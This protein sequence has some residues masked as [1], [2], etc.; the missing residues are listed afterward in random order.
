MFLSWYRSLAQVA[1][2]KSE[3]KT[4]G[5]RPQRGRRKFNP[6]MTVEL[7]EYRLAPATAAQLSLPT[8]GFTGTPGT[9]VANYPISMA[10]LS[11]GTTGTGHPIVGLAA[12]TIAVTYDPNAFALPLGNQLA[13]GYVSLGTI[14]LSDSSA[15]GGQADWTLSANAT[16]TAGVGTLAISLSAKTGDNIKTNT[17]GGTLLVLNFPVS[18]TFNPAS[19]TVE[20]IAVVGT[21]GSVHTS[22]NG[23]NGTYATASLGLGAASVGHITINPVSQGN[24][25]PVTPQNFSTGANTM[26]NVGNPA[27]ASPL[28]QPAAPVGGG[29]TLTVGAT[30]YYEVTAVTGTGAA[31]V[32]SSPSNQESFSPTAS[33]G[34][35]QPANRTVTL[36]WA[37]VAGASSYKIYRSNTPYVYGPS[38]LVGTSAGLQF[39]DSGV[40]AL[41][42]GMP[43]SGLLTGATDPQGQ[44]M[45]V[46]SVDGS[47]YTP[48]SAFTLPSGGQVIINSN[49]SFVYTPAADYVGTDNFTYTLA[50]QG[51]NVSNP[52]TASILVTPTL[53]I[54]PNTANPTNTGKQGD[55][56][57]EDVY[58]D[59]PN[60][61]GGFGPLTGFNLSIQYLNHDVLAANG[62]GDIALIDG[63]IGYTT[64]PIVQITGGLGTGATAHVDLV[65][66]GADAGGDPIQDVVIDSPGTGYVQPPAMSPIP[67]VQVKFVGGG[68]TGATAA[69]D[70]FTPQIVAGPD[71]PSDWTAAFNAA[72]TSS[73]ANAADG[74]I[75][76]GVFGNGTAA[77]TVAAPA[78]LLLATF[79]VTIVGTT[80]VPGSGSGSPI[81]LVSTAQTAGGPASTAINGSGGTFPLNPNIGPQDSA[82]VPGVDTGIIILGTTGGTLTLTPATGATFSG[83]ENVPFSQLFTAS[84]G[85][86]SYTFSTT[87]GGL[88]VGVTLSPSGVLSGAP[89]QEGSY[90][91]T[92]NASDTAAATGS[93]TYT[94]V[95]ADLPPTVSAA[96]TSVTVP[97]NTVATNTG[98]YSDY[99]DPVSVSGPGVHDNG[100]GT[101]S[102]S[103]TGDE[104]TPQTITVTAT[105]GDGSSSETTFTV[106]FTDVKPVVSAAS[107]LITVPEN[108]M[109]TNSGTYSDFD[110]A[111]SVSGPGVTDNHNGTWSWSGTGDELTPQTI[112]VTATNVDGSS[113][114]TAFTVKFT[115][116]KPV[117][118][119]ASTSITVPENTTATNSGTYSDFDDAVSVSGPGV[120]DNHNGTW[121][122]SGTGDEL[123]P[124]TITV[125]A[126]NID[127]SSSTTTFT[128][129]FTDVKPVVTAAST[130]VSAPEN[131]AATNSGTYSDFDDAVSVSGPGVTDNHNGTWSWSGT[132]DE[133]TPQT[134][135]V[136]A[137]NADG[138]SSTTTFTVHFTDVKPVV[139]AASTS[140]TVPENTTATNSGTYSD[141]DDA[142][143][144]SGPGVTDNHNGTWSWS[145]TGDELT[146]QT[147]TVTA[148]NVDGSSS[149]TTFTVKFTDVAPVVSAA[150]TA[151]SAPEN[152]AATNTGTYSDFDDTVSVSGPGVTD[153]HNG[154]WSWSGT[155]D[156]LTPYDVTVTATNVDGSSS[157][158]TFHVSFTDVKPT[159]SAASPAVTAP[160]GGTA[161]NTGT[162]SDFDDAVSVSGPGVTDNH[163]GTWSW[164][165]TTT[166]TP[167]D[168]TVTATNAD[169]STN[170]TT[171]LV[172]STAATP[173]VTAAST[174]VSAAENVAATNNGFYS[175]ATG[176][177]GPGVVDHHDGTWS[178]SGTGDELTPYDVTVT[179]TNGSA[180]ATTTFH[181]SFTDVKPAVSAASTSVTVPEN[182]TATN[183]GT[184]SDFDD[185]VSVSGPGVT[186]NHNGTWSWSGTGDE[187]TPQTVTVTATNA[188]GATSTTTFTVQFTD[189]KPV[190]SAASTS[191]TVP[192]NTTATNSGT[193]S[194]FDDAVSVSGPGVTDNHNGTWS[195]SGTGDELAPQTITVTATN[196]D[197]SSSTTT[198]TVHFTDVKPV[199]SAASTSVTAPE[200]SAATNSG[201]YSDFDDAVSVSGPGVTDNHNGTWSW[202]GTGDE[203]TPQ[204]ITV[205]ATNADGSSS[206]TTFSVHFT[207]V[208][209]SVSAASAAVSAPENAAATNTGTYS[210][211]DDAVSVSGP[212]VTDN[213]NGTWSWSGTGDE[214][215]PYNVTVTATNADGST[216]TTTFHVSF[217]D[218]KPVVTAD[219]TSVTVPENTTATVSGTYS[220]FDDAVSVSGPGVVD[221]HDGTW[222]WSGTGDELTPLT[223]TV[224]ATNAD[225]S[226]ATTALSVHFTEV[227]PTFVSMAKTAL[228]TDTGFT[229]TNSG[230][231]SE[232]D[233]PPLHISASQGTLTDH[234]DGTW[235]WSQTGTTADSG[236]VT[237]TATN[238]DGTSTS[239]M[240]TVLF[241]ALPTISTA[242]LQNGRTGTAYSQTVHTSGGTAPFT[243]T[244]TGTLPAGL[245]L[246]PS[247]GVVSGTPTTVGSSTFTVSATDS[248][249]NSTSRPYTVSVVQGTFLG[250][251][252][253]GFMGSEGTTVAAFPVSIN[254]LQDNGSFNG[255]TN[256]VG[257]A[258]ANF[259]ITFPTG[260][261]AFPVGSNAATAFVHLGSVP[262][263]FFT[264]TANSPGDGSLNITLQAQTGHNITT[265]TPPGGGTLVTIDFPVSNTF[266]PAVDTPETITLV[267]AN[268]SAHTQVQGNNGLY[269]LSPGPNYTGSITVKN[270]PQFP[271]TIT[272]PQS[273]VL[274]AN[275][276]L[277]T[278]APG[279]LVGAMDP[280]HQTISVNRINGAVITPG[281]PITLPSGGILQV[282]ANGAFSYTPASNFVGFDVFTFTA[283]DQGGNESSTG[284]VNIM[285]TATLSLHPESVS[286]GPS[287]T[288]VV[289]DVVLDNPA[290][291]GGFGPLQGFNVALTYDSTAVATAPDGSQITVG[292]N[293]PG[294]WTFDANAGTPGVIAIG[295]FN[296]KGDTVS[297]PSPLVLASIKFT[298]IA[299]ANQQT[300]VKIVPSAKAGTSIATTQLTGVGGSYPLNPALDGPFFVNGV[301]TY[302]GVTGEPAPVTLHPDSPLPGDD[303]GLPYLEF[304]NAIGGDGGPFS[305]SITGGSL[306]PGIT[307]ATVSDPQLL[308]S[309]TPTTPG[310]FTFTVTA[311]DPSSDSGSKLYSITI[312]PAVSITTTT[313]PDWTVNQPGYNST[314]NATGGTGSY[315]FG[316]AS[317]V[318]PNG[319]NLSASGV[320]SGTPTLAGSYSFSVS[321]S[322]TLGST[323]TKSYTVNINTPVVITTTTLP[324]WTV[325]NPGYNKTIAAT[326]GTGSKTFSLTSGTLP[327]GLGLSS[328]GVVSGTPTVTGTYTFAVTATDT[329]GASGSQSYT[330][331]INPAVV[332]TT[333]TLPD[334]TAGFAGYNQTIAATG[335]TGTLTFSKSAGTVPTGLI[336]SSSG[337]LSGTPTVAGTYNFTITA[338]DTVGATGSQAYTVVINPAVVITTTTLPN[339]T[340]NQPNYG[341]AGG[342][343]ISATGGT[344]SK[345]FAT[346]GGTLPTGLALS[347]SGVLS[348][349]PTATGSFTFQVTAT[350]SIG[351]TSSP[352]SYTVVI[353]SAVV[354]TTTTLPNWTVNRP[355]Y[356]QNITATG[357]TGAKTFSAPAASLPTGMTLSS[358]G[359]LSGTP[360]VTGSYTFTVTATDTVGATGTQT[361][362]VVINSTPVITTTSLPN[363]TVNAPGY[364]QTIMESGGTAPFTYAKTGGTL[365]TGLTLSAA[366]V[367]SGTPTATGTFLFTITLT[368]AAS[369]TASQNYSVTISS[370]VVITTTTLANSTEGVAG[371]NQ[372]ITATGGTGAKTFSA[373]AAS[374]PT[375]LTLSSSGVLSGTPTVEGSY[376]FTVTATD[377]VGATGSKAFTVVIADQPPVVKADN[378]LVTAAENTM[379]TNTGTYSDFDDA[380]SVSGP[381][382]T[383]NHDGTW[384]WSGSGDELTPQT[385]TVTATNVD[386]TK[387]TTTFTAKFTD[388][389]PKVS[390]ASTSIT[391]PENT[392]ATNTGT[393]SDFDDAVSVS[394]P[395]VTDN[396]NGTWS[397]SGTGDELT[398]QTVTVTATNADGSSSSTTFTVHFTDVPPVVTEASSAITATVGSTATNSGTYSDFDDAVS[399]SGPGVTDNHNGTWSWS[400][401]SASPTTETI[402]VTATNADGS[403][404]ST[405]FTVTFTLANLDV[406]AATTLV[407]TGS[408]TY[409]LVTIEGTLIDNGTLT[410]ASVSL[411]GPGAVLKGT[412]SVTGPVIVTSMGSGSTIGGS[413]TIT[414]PGGT[415]ID[416]QAGAN[417]VSISGV[418]VTGSIIA[419]LD[420]PGSGNMT[421]ITGNTITGNATGLEFLNGCDTATGNLIN[422]N[423]VGVLIPAT[424]P[425]NPS[426]PVNPLL[427]LEGNDLSG[428]SSKGMTNASTMGVTAILNWWG[429]ASGT[430]VAAQVSGV[431]VDNY[432][433]YA[434]DATSVGPTP[435]TFDFFNGTGTDGNVY[436]TGT[437][438]TDNIV[439]TVDSVNTN[440]VHVTG[441]AAPG[442][443]LRGGASN[444]II[445]YG[446][447]DNVTGA[448]DS[449]TFGGDTATAPWGAQINTEALKYREPIG[450]GGTSSSKVT[451]TGFGNDVIFGGG[452]DNISDKTSGN[453]VVVVGLST[454]KT[455]APTAPQ[456]ATGS[457]SDIV[458]AGFIDCTLAPLASTGRLDY[459]S[460]TAIDAL[461]A[462]SA[463]GSAGA[464]SAPALYSVANTPGAIETGTARAVITPAG[465][466][467]KTWYVVKGAGNPNNT[468]TGADQD[469]VN[470]SMISPNYRQAIQ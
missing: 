98:T 139:S 196:A 230:V 435:T 447:G 337:V 268:G 372:T 25:V 69:V 77:D 164:S 454:G 341:G 86:G 208:A 305:Y 272:T 216:S 43:P 181:V 32:E 121:S 210:D 300:P 281:M 444:R 74:V 176:V 363:W 269:T 115:D 126:T 382:V 319:L 195:W 227:A 350:D 397:W 416:V 224:T 173:T 469:Y 396:H 228:V 321:A 198:F 438:G 271:P 1:A 258:V 229:V 14:P 233:D 263:S 222:S 251:P 204:T 48:G 420:E 245:S 55:V 288:M 415:A 33:P 370:A 307:S 78:P 125:T 148:T 3:K 267:S 346:T 137:T 155:G 201:T 219:S 7:L 373:P 26:L 92:V 357:G 35:G 459:E 292:S 442:N 417:N 213:H 358:S 310:T 152:A 431:S 340:V 388:V 129:H 380:V 215:T 244:E 212:G 167:Y 356:S 168:V 117:V 326:G 462:T 93:G 433:P 178:W 97:E 87:P 223:I 197:G 75:G 315:T 99:D 330:V 65:N 423:N 441:S 335:G 127:G 308:L 113:S 343:T 359:L 255:G 282:Q 21:S 234:G 398:P 291:A 289:E 142:V 8:S 250:M 309:G 365:P 38:S 266:N 116:V 141:Y 456:V 352:R 260:V 15:P 182:T 200:N 457:G 68:G 421:S 439:A 432:T 107:T 274:G 383:D 214:L 338:T 424:N 360:T 394:G 277:N 303:V 183:S 157:T 45:A 169:G 295:A 407:L 211:F 31:A 329:V 67:A 166:A 411:D 361:Y 163:N 134:V 334:W 249:G 4:A 226:T 52:A 56:L 440:L 463:G 209:P 187:L 425:G 235:N 322:D 312:N 237:V 301:D 140:I 108:T 162:Y 145:G 328:S 392:A 17:G 391:V 104:L 44:A 299:T 199:V 449:I 381:G 314:I 20:N 102:W 470:G 109:A 172:S 84:G 27:N 189:V 63:G 332:I 103:G 280:Q 59:D 218:V 257:L 385:I 175:N 302:I 450:F 28:Q 177:S 106:H 254:Q 220:D 443:Y 57:L 262:T 461:W 273:Y 275:S 402:T 414:N 203:L 243:F 118:S 437:L 374:L 304:I 418:T 348:G 179:A 60:P 290:P 150:S 146:P 40:A 387:S 225:G 30:Y 143:S 88:P 413:L 242:T 375:G 231:F 422:G 285:V 336:L 410:A 448:K 80:S 252:S 327:T 13:S 192:E 24:P 446:F 284:T 156:E 19:S 366:G 430:A 42:P 138:N 246:N 339:W 395:G 293:I 399:V 390:A 5:R 259:A 323:D 12:T 403:S 206:T 232:Y 9:T 320:L 393:Y 283:I 344:G 453:N 174:S 369:A 278:P 247:T 100:N 50:D 120:T 94:L 144:V 147:I 253:S 110:D 85:N 135:T 426:L 119:A 10:S 419:V 345:T 468:P 333:T 354:I 427:T 406:P 53:R 186:D 318:L 331:T 261:F 378:T 445:I 324:D 41:S 217:T 276:T 128:V 114:T 81:Q 34:S 287:G 54:T 184:Y 39:T 112:T 325:N 239:T 238:A 190:V 202:S 132:G 409:N 371:Y 151:V 362:T 29:T 428:N 133:L 16:V 36:S 96:S 412:G 296:P 389:A 111:V 377:T 241:N 405:S 72:S 270:T 265:N 401:T 82:P 49:G 153:N 101:W 171:F 58:L 464:M 286:S 298:I 256:H 316:L 70:V 353:N 159:V 154:T 408:N 465:G 452:N 364:S 205:T 355:G 122:W 466:T 185:T 236:T 349:T 458:I 306:P 89:A 76:I 248:I 429:S 342:A 404:S 37:A 61:A 22:V 51:G 71:L 240:F 207:D 83:T 384:S 467:S 11:D 294:D 347:S 221:H 90:T 46:N 161:T 191:I 91:F 79:A 130:A 434:L 170:T 160:E 368:D 6:R 165:G 158:T 400:G 105:N 47:S 180:T 193:Y 379:A 123:T 18:N 451:V 264:I 124:Q 64:A 23:N 386:G 149:T 194:D 66:G 2:L 436:V 311:T 95:V 188:D 136:T 62:I 279:L 460:L 367:L 317:G 455:G 297:G 351:A 131:T 313:L 376:T 73:P